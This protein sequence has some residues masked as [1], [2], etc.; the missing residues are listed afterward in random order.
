MKLQ[1]HYGE[2]LVLDEN[3]YND[4][5]KESRNEEDSNLKDIVISAG[6]D[7]YRDLSG[8]VGP[9]EVL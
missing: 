4:I 3:I 9:H 6:N 8:E 7:R 5:V 1:N 2:I